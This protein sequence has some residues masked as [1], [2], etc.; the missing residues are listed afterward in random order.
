MALTERYVTTTGTDTYAN[1]TNIATPMSLSTAITNGTAGDRINIKAGTYTRSATDTIAGAGTV[2]SPLIW[3]GY[4]STP[5]DLDTPVQST[6]NLSLT[7]TN[8]PLIDYSGNSANRFNW[9]GGFSLWQNLYI[10]TAY[11]GNSILMN[12]GNQ[13]A[14]NCKFEDNGTGTSAVALYMEVRCTC[15][16]CDISLTGASGGA[17]AVTMNGG[18]TGNRIIGSYIN[19]GPATGIL[20]QSGGSQVLVCNSV[21]AGHTKHGISISSAG[22]SAFGAII[23]YNTI[24]KKTGSGTFD[25]INVATGLTYHHVFVGN[26]ITDHGGTAYG[27]NMVSTSNAAFLAFNRTR[28]NTSGAIGNGGDWI[29]AT[30]LGHVTT[31]TGGPETDYTDN[32]TNNF[33][34]ISAAPAKGAGLPAYL[35]IGAMQRQETAGGGGL[36]VHPG[37]GGGMI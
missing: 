18:T 28:D 16:A 26:H 30:T 3:R 25:A 15:V 1:S 10:K 23:L 8:F 11:D 12:G 32:A 17:N 14:Y 7:T 34:L 31:D 27:I 19:G 13:A 9:T 2:T 4:N 29:T 35:D 33:S 21:I 22:G 6:G 5:G 37:M 24:C 36:L 20:L